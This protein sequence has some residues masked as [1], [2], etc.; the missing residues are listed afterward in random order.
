MDRRN[1]RAA[2]AIPA[3]A[4][5]AAALA[6]VAGA[7]VVME[8]RPPHVEYRG[9]PFA[10]PQEARAGE[11]VTSLY[12]ARRNRVCPEIE[13]PRVVSRWYLM[14][15]DGRQP[16]EPTITFETEL[17][18]AVVT[19]DFE[20]FLLHLEVPVAVTPGS[21]VYWPEVWCGDERVMPE[22]LA[23]EVTD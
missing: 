5:L 6:V 11:T 10:H 8:G 18:Q 21:W 17:R 23:V 22:P 1:D 20:P 9:T 7:I 4:W 14:G 3:L 15:E 19:P 2:I 16:L 13:S 12:V